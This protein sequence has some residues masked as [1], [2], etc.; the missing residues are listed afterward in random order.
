M[1]EVT[2]SLLVIGF[3]KKLRGKLS[4]DT[5][6][7]DEIIQLCQLFFIITTR[8]MIIYLQNPSERSNAMYLLDTES[9]RISKFMGPTKLTPDKGELNNLFYVP[10]NIRKN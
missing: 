10:K 3:I 9:K 4:E 6:I 5:I 2:K 7:P 8:K 1:T